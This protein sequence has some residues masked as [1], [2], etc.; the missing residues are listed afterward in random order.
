[1]PSAHTFS[2]QRECVQ[3]VVTLFWVSTF[4]FSEV[5][6]SVFPNCGQFHIRRNATA[7]CLTNRA[8]FAGEVRNSRTPS[9][10]KHG[11]SFFFAVLIA[12]IAKCE[13]SQVPKLFVGEYDGTGFRSQWWKAHES[14]F[15]ILARF[16]RDILAVPVSTISS[17]SAFSS[18]GRILKEKTYVT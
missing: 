16:A 5:L 4:Q 7:G 14:T 15:L 9:Q 10:K 6:F 1:M 17:E 8:S 2:F 11:P 13:N 12:C 18:C 3:L